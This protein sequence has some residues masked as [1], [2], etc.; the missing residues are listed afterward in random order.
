[1]GITLLAIV[2]GLVGGLL[3]G[4]SPRALRGVR[5]QWITVLVV[6]VVAVVASRLL[7]LAM[8]GQ[9]LA[10]RIVFIAGLG[11]L[12]I[13]A[14]RNTRRMPA[15]W[16]FAF[17]IGLNIAVV[18]ANGSMIYRQSSLISAGIVAADS[19]DV[20]NSSVH[21]RPEAESDR[22]SD[23]GQHIAIDAWVVSEVV[24]PGDLL[25]A[26]G[27]GSMLFL[28][29]APS[30][31][32]MTRRRQGIAEGPLPG[33]VA[34]EPTVKAPDVKAPDVIRPTGAVSARQTRHIVVVQSPGE[35]LP[36][37]AVSPE[38]TDAIQIGRARAAA[39][40]RSDE[41]DV[42]VDLTADRAMGSHRYDDAVELSSAMS[43]IDLVDPA[44]DDGMGPL[45]GETFW[46]AR[47]ALR[48]HQPV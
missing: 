18:V 45:P 23:L 26:A 48:S 13:G 40:R 34:A 2:L 36:T 8:P 5:P 17:G 46:A 43:F 28:A 47:A 31:R 12:C 20:A 22:L 29:L 44:A 3:A 4:G 38:E 24:S 37:E 39:V 19:S 42:L 33:I 11:L 30:K 27:A 16:L 1:M 35:V 32:A 6:G 41:I 7:D 14:L 15:A 21:G 10:I 25:M 9:T